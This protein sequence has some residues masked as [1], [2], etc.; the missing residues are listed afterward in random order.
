MPKMMTTAALPIAASTAVVCTLW[1]MLEASGAVAADI[2]PTKRLTTDP[3]RIPLTLGLPLLLPSQ[4]PEQL[5]RAIYVRKSPFL[6][7][8]S[9]YRR[10]F[11]P[12]LARAI[13]QDLQPGEVSTLDFDWRYGAAAKRVRHLRFVTKDEDGMAEVSVHFR[14]DGKPRTTVIQMFQRRSGWRIHDVA[15]IGDPALHQPSWS[16]RACL[17]MHGAVMTPSCDKPARDPDALKPDPTPPLPPSAPLTTKAPPPAS[18]P[19]L[20]P[21]K[22]APSN[23]R[24]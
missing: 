15:Q 21:S 11:M 19:A 16:I 14:V 12:D 20:E 13:A 2:A 22:A 3:P 10:A 23:R 8:V 7:K 24:R 6:G 18:P 9:G 5:V 1:L 17:H 4:D